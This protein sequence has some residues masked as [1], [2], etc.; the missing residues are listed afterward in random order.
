MEGSNAVGWMVPF[1]ADRCSLPLCALVQV[2]QVGADRIE[3]ETVGRLR[4]LHPFVRAKPDGADG[5]GRF[6]VLREA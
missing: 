5:F 3:A 4:H 1:V 2:A 6:L